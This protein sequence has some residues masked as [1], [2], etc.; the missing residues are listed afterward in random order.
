MCTAAIGAIIPAMQT[1][2][3]P[4]RAY[5]GDVVRLDV[6]HLDEL[7]VSLLKEYLSSDERIVGV[8]VEI[9]KLDVVASNTASSEGMAEFLTIKASIEPLVLIVQFVHT[10]AET[11]SQTAKEVAYRAATGAGTTAAGYLI[12][13]LHDWTKRKGSPVDGI[14]IFG[15]DGNVV[16]IVKPRARN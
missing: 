2:G 8:A 7:E 15:A 9:P 1:D 3:R 14:R 10:H 13:K 12:K 16:K 5:D 6:T 4:D 11:I